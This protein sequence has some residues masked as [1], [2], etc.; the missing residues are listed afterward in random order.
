[1]TINATNTLS[2]QQKDLL[3]DATN[4]IAPH[5]PLDKLIAVNPLWSLVD[6]PFDEISDELS[7]LAGI[8]TYLPIETYRTWFEE[9]RISR[10]CLVKAAN[11]Y[12]LDMA[13]ESL[14]EYLSQPNSLPSPMAQP[15]RPCGSTK[16]RQIK[17][18]GTM[19]SLIKLANFA[20][21]I[22]NSKAQP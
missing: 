3:L 8:K 12:D 7:A 22:T 19:K 13:P 10:A 18:H 20:P 11:H 15:C 4:T 1:M 9:G 5:W 14:L 6:K 16:T 17:C 21:R 2:M